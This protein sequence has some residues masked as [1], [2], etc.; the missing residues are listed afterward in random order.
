LTV[1]PVEPISDDSDFVTVPAVTTPPEPQS[2]ASP[3]APVVSPYQKQLDE[4]ASMGFRDRSF[5]ESLL[6]AH[7]GN[8]PEV[9]TALLSSM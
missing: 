5:N 3:P 6:L 8:L 7:D 1:E 4:L 2:P 9:V